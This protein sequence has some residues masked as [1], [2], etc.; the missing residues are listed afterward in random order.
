MGTSA[1][2]AIFTKFGWRPAA[3]LSVGFTGISILLM[4]ARGP[5][6]QRYT[7]IGWEGGWEMRKSR[8]QATDDE[9]KDRNE[10][11]AVHTNDDVEGAKAQ[12]LDSKHSASMT[13]VLTLMAVSSVSGEKA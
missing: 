5:H 8:L 10:A 9:K 11:A 2:T 1:G 13:Y 7:W 6:V 12:H 3:A 4:L